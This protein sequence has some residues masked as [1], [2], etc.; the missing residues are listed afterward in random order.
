[1]NTVTLRT[2]CGC[3]RG[4]EDQGVRIFRGIPYAT[5]ERFEKPVLL[6]HWEGELDATDVERDCWQYSAFRDEKATGGS[7]Y[8][9][10]FRREQ[11]IR[12]GESP[13][14]L[15]I[16][17]PEGAENCPVL[18]FFHGGGHET[19]TIGEIPYGT[20]REYAD[21]GIVYV[22]VGYRLNIFSLYA[23]GNYGLHD[24]VA[25]I[26]WVQKHIGDF[27]GDP[28]RIT[29]MGQSAGAMSVTN[30]CYS[31]TL[32]GLVQGA[33]LISGGGCIP[34]LAGPLTKAEA[35]PFW[36]AVRNRAGA[37]TEEQMRTLPPQTIWEAWYAEARAW[38]D[39]RTL[40]PGIDG[41]I[42]PDVPQEVLKRQEDLDVPMI[43]SVTSQDF[44]PVVMFEVAQRWAMRSHRLGRKPVYGYFFD[45]T[46]PGNRYK[47]FHAA[48]LWYLFGSMDRSW[49]PFE[50][51][52]YALAKRMMD[53][54]AAFVK[55]GDPNGEGL[56]QWKPLSSRQKKFCLF[57][58]VSQGMVSPWICRWKLLRTMLWD[59]GPM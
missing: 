31:Q 12:Y 37:E 45:R 33:I 26:R 50:E 39:L 27:G 22:S 49:R 54:M 20:T 3:L 32:K 8:Y 17:T 35:E 34:R 46:P 52:D 1:M 41:E 6:H 24:Q 14:E 48:D 21:R 42:I 57:D 5:S 29:I 15:T 25:A 47:A 51:T 16:V 40:Q 2:G 58:G 13:Q 43:F 11:Q 44:M 59:K 23:C 30:L 10:E 7:F 19:G 9:Q 38:N 18:V 28:G 55:T 53:H 4:I 56:P 36:Q